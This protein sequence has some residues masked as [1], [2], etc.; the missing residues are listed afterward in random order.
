MKKKKVFFVVIKQVVD[1]DTVFSLESKCHGETRGLHENAS[2]FRLK[3]HS[4]SARNKTHS[5]F[6]TGM[7]FQR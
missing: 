5:S 1:T 6:P 7:A 4:I 2:S 3:F